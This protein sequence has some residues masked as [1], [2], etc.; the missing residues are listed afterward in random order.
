[1]T[2]TIDEDIEYENGKA[3][4]VPGVGDFSKRYYSE[5]TIT[6]AT[7]SEAQYIKMDEQCE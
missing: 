4:L 2:G 3:Y 1:V 6:T 7:A 5:D